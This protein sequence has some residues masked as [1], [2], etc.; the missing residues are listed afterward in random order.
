MDVKKTSYKAGNEPSSPE[1]RAKYD[2]D[3]KGNKIEEGKNSKGSQLRRKTQ[4]VK[5]NYVFIEEEVKAGECSE[6]TLIGEIAMLD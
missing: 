4:I 2:K 1:I 5:D 3:E 6:G